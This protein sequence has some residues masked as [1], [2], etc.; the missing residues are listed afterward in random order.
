MVAFL[1]MKLL[2]EMKMSAYGINQN[3]A[4][5]QHDFNTWRDHK[6]KLVATRS[7]A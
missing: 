1:C 4:I 2:T 3:Y 7:H 5:E 6:L